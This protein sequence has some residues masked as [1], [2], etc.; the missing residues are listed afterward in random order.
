MFRLSVFCGSILEANPSARLADFGFRACGF[1]FLLLL[2]VGG[3]K[4]LLLASGLCVLGLHPSASDA[5]HRHM[6]KAQEKRALSVKT[7]RL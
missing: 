2:R 7:F 6:S 1:G 4:F 3:L 5:H